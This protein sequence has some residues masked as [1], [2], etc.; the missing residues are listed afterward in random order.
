MN[1]RAPVLSWCPT[2]TP[3]FIRGSPEFFGPGLTPAGRKYAFSPNNTVGLRHV[4]P[5]L[6]LSPL[7]RP[8]VVRPVGSGTGRTPL[9]LC[10]KLSGGILKAHPLQ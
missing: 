3:G 6:R 9:S 10:L 5:V 4:R 8:V 2:N 1:N 7:L